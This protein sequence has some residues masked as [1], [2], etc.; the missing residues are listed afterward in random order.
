MELSENDTSSLLCLRAIGKPQRDRAVFIC[1]KGG[2]KN[3]GI[4]VSKKLLQWIIVKE[5]SIYDSSFSMD[6]SNIWS[7]S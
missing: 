3:R 4:A 6:P 1:V 2:A 7:V 5:F